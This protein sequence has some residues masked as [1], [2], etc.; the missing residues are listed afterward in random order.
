MWPT[1]IKKQWRR[2]AAVCFAFNASGGATFASESVAPESELTEVQDPEQ[3]LMQLEKVG[4][5]RFVPER[6]VWQV[7]FSRV[8]TLEKLESQPTSGQIEVIKA[9][10]RSELL[11]ELEKQGRVESVLAKGGQVCRGG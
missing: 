4:A 6:D 9:P 2:I 10:K 8:E 7:D 3:M 1:R 11:R 5:V